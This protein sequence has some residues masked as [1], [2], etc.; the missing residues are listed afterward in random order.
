MKDKKNRKLFLGVGLALF[1]FILGLGMPDFL[2]AQ[3]AKPQPKVITQLECPLGCGTVEG[4][5]I[6]G[7]FVAKEHPWLV[8]QAQETPGW[9]Y[10]VREV[11]KNQKRWKNTTFGTA[12]TIMQLYFQGGRKEIKEFYPEPIKIKWKLLCGS[13]WWTQG[14]WFVTTNP[15]IKS[16]KDMKG[17]KIGLGL[18]T[19]SDWGGD[20][21]IMLETGYGITPENSTIRHLGPV[22][23]SEAMLDGKVDVVSMGMGTDAT[24]KIWMPAGPMRLLEA[25]G[26]K[27]YYLGLDQSVI[28]KVNKKYKTSYMLVTVPKGTLKGQDQ[29]FTAGIDRSYN[30]C[31]P[32]FPEDLAYEYVKVV[33][34][35]RQR[36]AEV[37]PLWKTMNDVTLLHGLSEETAHP[38]AIRAYKEAGI[39][40][41]T[42]KFP[43]MKYPE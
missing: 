21:R 33:L 15:K 2:Q 41:L 12:E 6:L 42:K 31:H 1:I 26:R 3:P 4:Y 35:L 5:T 10:N 13:T 23:A 18:R 39:W 43:P 28:D 17:K 7:S 24:F 14:M 20:A 29:E 32:E 40:D 25:S 37:H 19:Q 36:M 8:I 34:S 27:L 38:G 9:L 22:A 30:A 16:I 11:G